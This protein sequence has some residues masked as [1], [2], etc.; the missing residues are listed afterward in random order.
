ML[1]VAET[2]TLLSALRLSDLCKIF[3]SFDDGPSLSL[4]YVLHH[5]RVSC[6][7]DCFVQVLTVIVH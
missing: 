3:D 6:Y 1:C 5:L 7:F 4:E 2:G